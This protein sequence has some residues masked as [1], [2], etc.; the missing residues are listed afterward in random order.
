MESKEFLIKFANEMLTLLQDA[1][2]FA[3]QEIPELLKEVIVY[4]RAV[5]TF[6]IL[7]GLAFFVVAGIFV[8]M[9][10]KTK[11]EDAQFGGSILALVVSVIGAGFFFANLSQ[12]IKAWFAP[13]LYLI[14]YFKEML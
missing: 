5:N 7:V 13:R 12:A 9:A 2:A 3:S 6:Y 10:L 11:S 14:D 1:K 8:R 4:G